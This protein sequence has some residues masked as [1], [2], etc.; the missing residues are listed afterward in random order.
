VRA[1]KLLPYI[2]I[3]VVLLIVLLVVGK[4]VG[5]FGKEEVTKVAVEKVQKRDITETITA[6]GKVQPE[7][8]V[9]ITPEVS[10]EI[11]E[12]NVKE[13]DMVEKGKLLVLIKPDT[14]KSIRDQSK[15]YVNSAKARLAQAQ[16]SYVQS[17]LSYNRSK[18]LWDQ[19]AISES[20]YE[21]ALASYKIAGAELDAAQYSVKSAEA[22]LVEAEENLIKTSIYAPLTGTIFNLKVEKGERVLGTQMMTGTELMRIADLT[23]MEVEVEVNEN[24]IVRVNMAD[25]ASIEV[26]AYL[27]DKFKGVVTEIS[28]AANTTGLST[29]QVTNF[30]VKIFILQES[31]RHINEQGIK[32]PFR[33][34]MSGTVDIQT[35]SKYAILTV[36]IQ[37]VTTRSDSTLKESEI[38][39]FKEETDETQVSQSPDKKPEEEKL[40]E[41]V[42]TIK[43]GTAVVKEVKS[44]IQDNNYIEILEGVTEGED[45]IIAPYAAVSKKLKDGSP[46]EVVPYADLFKTEKKKK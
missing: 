39:D 35:D 2:I 26:D 34:G 32:N 22:A 5:W 18:K 3:V 10:G 37:A 4:K 11:V 16:A 17:E 15:A 24:D 41:L 27:G 43:D 31:Y 23:R 20:E 21:N 7:T 36:P 8:E 1:K 14:Y 9:I 45:I 42:F 28:N 19:Q 12:L 30:N 25:T 6:N 38:T 44:G 29:D 40:H 46:V 33:P 13:G